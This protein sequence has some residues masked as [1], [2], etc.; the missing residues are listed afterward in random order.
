MD[1]LPPVIAIV[2]RPNVGKSTLLNALVRSRVAIVEETPGVTRDR[3][4]V[5]CTLADRTVEVVDTGGIGIVDRPGLETHVE[6]Q[7]DTAVADADVVLF[8][9]DAREGVT[10]LDRR[11]ANLLRSAE[12]PVVL[13]AN[14][15]ETN[16]A[17]WGVGELEVL[18]HG[19]PMQISAKERRGLDD[20][21]EKLAE[22][23]QE[24]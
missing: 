22:L 4:A 1:A 3:V 20:L 11:V 2:G 14:K 12:A 16:E 17:E 6:S 23:L 7:V 5:I 15:V 19:T 9:T 24:R 13:L 10:A 21:E 18:G 8:V